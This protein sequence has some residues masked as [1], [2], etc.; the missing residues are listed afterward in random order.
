M[1]YSGLSEQPVIGGKEENFTKVQTNVFD[2]SLFNF[3]WCR[4]YNQTIFAQSIKGTVFT[5]TNHGNDW[6]NFNHELEK[7]ATIDALNP[8]VEL[9]DSDC[10]HHSK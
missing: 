4:S 10:E 8:Q 1:T 2:S 5:S 3:M 9:L 6:S 7:A